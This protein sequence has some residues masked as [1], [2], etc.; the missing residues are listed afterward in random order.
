MDDVSARGESYIG[1]GASQMEPAARPSQMEFSGVRRG[2]DGARGPRRRGQNTETRVFRPGT[3]LNPGPPFWLALRTPGLRSGLRAGPWAPSGSRRARAPSGSRESDVRFPR[4][5]NIVIDKPYEFV[6]P[7]RGTFWARG[8]VGRSSRGTCDRTR[9][10]VVRAHGVGGC[11][12][13]RGAGPRHRARA[14]SQPAVRS[15]WSCFSA[16]PRG[17]AAIHIMASWHL[18]MRAV[19]VVDVQPSAW[20][21]AIAKDW[22]AEAPQSR[23]RSSPT[24]SA[25]SFCFRKASSLRS[26]D[27]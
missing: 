2:Q 3:G 13:G 16:R 25:R 9:R 1:L 26:N 4:V 27:R 19:S 7:D 8:L 14:E 12:V 6:P 15:D 11:G 17:P 20:F 22:T 10:R 24:R 23:F 18:F 5:Q 21:S